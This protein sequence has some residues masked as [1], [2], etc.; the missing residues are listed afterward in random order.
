MGKFLTSKRNTF[1]RKIKMVFL[2]SFCLL[3]TTWI[4]SSNVED[5]KQK[6]NLPEDIKLFK[7][8]KRIDSQSSDA[9]LGNDEVIELVLGLPGGKGGFGSML[10]ALGNQ[11]QKTT[12][13]EAMRDLSGR[14]MRD[15]NEEKRLKDYVSKKAEREQIEV[16]EKDAKMK[17]LHKLV[18]E[19]E[20]K[21]EF[22]DEKYDKAR[23]E[24]TDRVHEALDQV[25]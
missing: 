14:R 15:I 1:L 9:N 25:F 11:I 10:R 21:H 22:K 19:G 2:R 23:E 17:K 8:G 18:T 7:N 16:E 13:H 3:T 12:N 20:S 24:A 6:L 4:D 5:L